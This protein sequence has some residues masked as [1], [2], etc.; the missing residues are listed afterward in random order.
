MCGTSFVGGSDIQK[1]IWIDTQGS[2]THIVEIF[3]FGNV[4]GPRATKWPK[5]P[6]KIV[7]YFTCVTVT[8][9][10]KPVLPDKPVDWYP[11]PFRNW[12]QPRNHRSM[13]IT[14]RKSNYC[15]RIASHGCPAH[16]VISNVRKGA[17]A[18][19]HNHVHH[20]PGVYKRLHPSLGEYFCSSGNQSTKYSTSQWV[21]MSLPWALTRHLCG[22]QSQL[23]GF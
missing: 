16:D 21:T 1:L 19:I 18:V 23:I 7:N 10:P 12:V 15:Q 2:L 14:G 4:S 11:G 20:I 13:A 8:A 6:I 17:H 9:K 3:K 5:L 22:L